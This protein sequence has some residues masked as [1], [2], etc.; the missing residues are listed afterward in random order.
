MFKSRN[1]TIWLPAIVSEGK[2]FPFRWYWVS[3]VQFLKLNVICLLNFHCDCK[4]VTKNKPT[5]QN[6]PQTLQNAICLSKLCLSPDMKTHQ[7]NFLDSTFVFFLPASLPLSPFLLFFS[8]FLVKCIMFGLNAFNAL[9]G[10]N[11]F[12]FSLAAPPPPL[13]SPLTLGMKRSDRMSSS[14]M[15]EENRFAIP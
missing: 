5:K 4:L 13:P 14:E 15:S 1:N 3:F 10:V 9:G 11:F 8:F 7:D 2:Y 6:K 12:S